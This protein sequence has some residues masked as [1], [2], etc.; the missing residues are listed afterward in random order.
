MSLTQILTSLHGRKLGLS[1]SGGLLVQPT[2]STG[3]THLAEISSAGVFNSSITSF[4][5]TVTE[6]EVAKLK[7]T[8]ETVS[9][10]AATILGY[11]MSVIS[12]D[13]INV[14]VLKLSAPEAG[15]LKEIFCDSSASTVSINTTANTITF[16]TSVNSSALVLDDAGGIRGKCIVLRGL[17]TTRWAM[18][19]HRDL[20]DPVVN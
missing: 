8:V 10:S 6:M 3:I 9:S 7:T 4:G 18:I 16:G 15:V 20:G 19:G 11:G 1:S 12:S 5:S 14:S 2:T 17:S 13:V